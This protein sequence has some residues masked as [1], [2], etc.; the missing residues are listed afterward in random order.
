MIGFPL[1]KFQNIWNKIHITNS[2]F[3]SQAK[4]E[5]VKK[6]SGVVKKMLALSDDVSVTPESNFSEMGADSLDMVSFFFSAKEFGI[7]A[8]YYFVSALKNHMFY[9]QLEILMVLEEEFDIIVHEEKGRKDN[10]IT[11]WAVADKIE[12]YLEKVD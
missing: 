6:V 1:I 8:R 5:T 9:F 10:I 2:T 3:S 12:K 7:L 11:V 4:P